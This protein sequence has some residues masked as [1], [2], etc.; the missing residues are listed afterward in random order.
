MSTV[1]YYDRKKEKEERYKKL[2]GQQ[3]IKNFF[4]KKPYIRQNNTD[5]TGE[6]TLDRTEDIVDK[7]E[8]IEQ[9]S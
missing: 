1:I 4:A 7:E 3:D 2:I 6:D 5:T 8:D 9:K